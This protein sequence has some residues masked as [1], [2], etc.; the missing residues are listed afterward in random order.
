MSIRQI[1]F[2]AAMLWEL[3]GQLERVPFAFVDPG[4]HGA[5]V[6]YRSAPATVGGLIPKPDLIF[7][8]AAGLNVI[9][10]D[11]LKM[12]VRLV[13]ME[14]QHMKMS[15]GSALK[16][17]RSAGQLPAFLAGA[18]M[19]QVGPLEATKDPLTCIWIHPATWQ[20]PLR[21]LEGVKK[22]EPGQGKELAK[23]YAELILDGDG[24]YVGATKA[25]R[26]GICDATA[27][28]LWVSKSLYMPRDVTAIG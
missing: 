3:R 20:S 28:A 19:A 4:V 11:L 9:G 2:K 25:Q 22:M 26:E 13:I 8:M 17:A 16:L 15:S 14:N 1:D 6:A 23:K 18:H 21:V 12:G 7:P 24:R 10:R 5:V 27:M